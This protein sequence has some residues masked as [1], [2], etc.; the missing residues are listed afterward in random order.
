MH[1]FGITQEIL[2]IARERAEAAGARKVTKVKVTVGA[3]TGVVEDSLR[4]YWDQLVPGT[5]VEGAELEVD[6][7]PITLRCPS[8]NEE[9]EVEDVA[10][11]C[12]KCSAF[13]P[14]VIAGKELQVSSLEV[15][16][17]EVLAAGD[18]SEEREDEGGETNA[19]Q[20]AAAQNPIEGGQ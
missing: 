17:G 3:M 6:N 15:E 9:S 4:F 2:R 18:E 7:V 11:V 5:I 12:P 13:G 14:E 10:L 1:E 16:G 20:E 19:G 8:C